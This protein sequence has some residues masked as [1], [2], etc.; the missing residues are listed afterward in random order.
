MVTVV[1]GGP[2]GTASDD[3]DLG[4]DGGPATKATLQE[5]IEL[6]FDTKGNLYIADRDNHAVRKVDTHGVIATVAGTGDPGYTGDGGPATKAKLYRP[7]GIA[8]T[9]DGTLYISDGDNTYVRKVDPHG[10]ISTIAGKGTK[11]PIDPEEMLLDANG[12]VI[13]SDTSSV[14][15]MSPTGL[16]T[17]IAGRENPDATGSEACTG[18]GGPATKAVITPSG[19]AVGPGGDLFIATNTCGVLRLGSN[20]ILSQYVPAPP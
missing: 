4:G 10:T 20:G 5:P 16:L 18:I 13:V 9:A 15:R 14:R 1:G 17:T 3:G 19:L 11:Q 8:V 12:H 2:P 7:Q 6:A